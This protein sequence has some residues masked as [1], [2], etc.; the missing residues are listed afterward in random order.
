MNS[1]KEVEVV[2]RRRFKL[3]EEPAPYD[4]GLSEPGMVARMATEVLEYQDNE[5]FLV[6]LLN[7]KNKVIGYQEVARGGIDM[8][9][10]D[11]RMVFR[12]AVLEGA[13]AI[14]VVHNHPSGDPAPSKED[15]ELTKRLRAG[16]ELLGVLV[17]DHLI[18]GGD[19]TYCSLA[20]KGMMS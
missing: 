2:V 8:C 9:P 15:L 13:S 12:A 14:I 18:V 1:V 16:G 4:V 5:S 6:F 11:P 20:E 19:G 10:V 17:L 3:G 7:V